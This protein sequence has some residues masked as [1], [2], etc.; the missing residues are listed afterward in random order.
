MTLKGSKTWVEISRAAVEQNI[1]ALR[2]FLNPGVEFCATVKANAYGHGQKEMTSILLDCGITHFAVDSI[3]EAIVLRDQA[4]YAVIFILGY[5]VIE[6]L[7]DVA[8]IN[9]IQTIYDED[10]II[11]LS[12]YGTSERPVMVSVKVETGLYRQGVGPRGLRNLLEAIARAGN[13]IALVSV[14][15]HFA[16]SEEPTDAMNAY[17]LQNFTRAIETI[18][19]AGF[20]PKYKHI[21]CSA[22]AMTNPLAQGTMTRYGIVMYGLWASKS[23]KR[24]VVLGRQNIELIPVLQWKTRIAQVKDV[25]SGSAIGYGGTHVTNRPIRLAIL[26]VGYADGLDRLLSN[27]GEVLI[28][29]RRCPIVG[30][31]CMNICMVDVSA[32]PAISVN[33]EATLIGR[34]GMHA[35]TA[36]DMATTIGTIHYEVVTR[37]SPSLPRVIC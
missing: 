5:T 22:A 1:A 35:T 21:A 9:A 8:R 31:I 2:L 12:K 19:A 18:K 34:D 13:R 30:N 26:P 17:Q 7:A 14:A 36:D 32:V 28:H 33:D 25:P 16:S 15:S 20:D 11:E 37:I 6:R 27:R 3:D 24:H 10:P 23:H 29:G 4:P